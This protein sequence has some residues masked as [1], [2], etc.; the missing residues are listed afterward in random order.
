MDGQVTELCRDFIAGVTLLCELS[1]YLVADFCMTANAIVKHLDIFKD[2][3]SR[4]LPCGEAI[5]MQA[6]RLQRAKEA[7]HR[8]IAPRGQ[9]ARSQ[10]FPFRLIDVCIP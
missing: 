10:Q 5:M 7:F 2:D 8:R 4:L 6:F 9:A 1:R 3:L